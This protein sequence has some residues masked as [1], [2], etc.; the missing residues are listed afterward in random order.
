ML[1]TFNLSVDIVEGTLI[2]VFEPVTFHAF[3]YL[4][5]SE[6]FCESL[7]F[8]VFF[9]GKKMLNSSVFGTFVA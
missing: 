2:F 4:K 7:K 3:N 6:S 5:I 8:F 1:F 9:F